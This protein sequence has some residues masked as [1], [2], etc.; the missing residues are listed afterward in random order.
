[1]Q[2]LRERPEAIKAVALDELH[3]RV[4]K[5][6]DKKGVPARPRRNGSILRVVAAWVETGFMRHWR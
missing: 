5:Q 2:R 1:L 6:P 3:G 4:C